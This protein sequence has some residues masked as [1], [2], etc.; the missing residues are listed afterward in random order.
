MASTTLD[1]NR[2]GKAQI[3]TLSSG[4]YNPTLMPASINTRISATG[5]GS[6]QRQWSAG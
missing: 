1:A 3:V 5:C 6:T 4:E 2:T